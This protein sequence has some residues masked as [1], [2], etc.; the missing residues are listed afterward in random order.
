M[1][2]ACQGH[3]LKKPIISAP[4]SSRN[5]I[6]KLPQGTSSKC[7]SIYEFKDPRALSANNEYIW[8][9]ETRDIEV[10]TA[11]AKREAGL[12]ENDDKRKQKGKDTVTDCACT[13]SLRVHVALLV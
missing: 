2:E 13:A 11:K 6:K 9:F 5:C 4:P 3:Y 8:H 1:R 7:E 12:L 10:A